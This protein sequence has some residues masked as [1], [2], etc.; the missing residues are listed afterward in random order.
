MMPN[1]IGKGWTFPIRP[2]PEGKLSLVSGEEKIRQSL[3]LILSTAPG[4]RKMYP[5][6]GC[7]IHDLVFQPNTEMLHAR[8]QNQVRDALIRYEPRIDVV[9]VRV[10]M[11]PEA[12]NF[13]IVRIDYRIRTS[14]SFY[15][16]VY[17]FFLTEGAG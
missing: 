1:L 8:V 7:G 12:R 6:F 13:L 2:N 9:D 14:N 5:E 10:E 15:N 16:L 4:E 11:P 17:P 3:L